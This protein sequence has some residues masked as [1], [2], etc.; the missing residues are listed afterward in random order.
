MDQTARVDDRDQRATG[1]DAADADSVVEDPDRVKREDVT[2][3]GTL[4]SPSPGTPGEGWGGGCVET[5][6]VAQ[7]TPT[8]TLPRSTGGGN[9]SGRAGA[10]GRRTRR[11]VLSGEREDTGLGVPRPV[12]PMC[13]PS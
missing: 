13:P 11:S 3:G 5:A 7:T 9:R 4:Y 6:P 12:A 10:T 1:D 2:K 8:L